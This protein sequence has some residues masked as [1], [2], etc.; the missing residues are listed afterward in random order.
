MEKV[1]YDSLTEIKKKYESLGEK[2]KSSD[3]LVNIK[4]YTKINK[5]F[6][7]LKDVT[8][9]FN[10]YILCENIIV[11]SKL[12][13]LESDEEIIQMAKQEIS[14]SEKKMKIYIEELKILLL[15]VDEN[16]DRNVIVEIRG[17]AGGDEANIFAG[18]LFRIYSK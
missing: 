6:N 15:P 13:L 11:D 12:M 3:V 17:A 5:E 10:E 18:D 7:M 4:L 8:N 9:K 1:M 16:D 14:E 2:L